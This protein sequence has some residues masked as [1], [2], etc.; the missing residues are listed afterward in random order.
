MALFRV[1]HP[2]YSINTLSPWFRSRPPS[3]SSLRFSPGWCLPRPP[4]SPAENFQHMQRRCVHTIRLVSRSKTK[5]PST[6]D[7]R[8][9]SQHHL[10]LGRPVCS[11]R[12]LE[13]STRAHQA[14]LAYR[15]YTGPSMSLTYEKVND[16]RAMPWDTIGS[17][18]MPSSKNLIFTRKDNSIQDLSLG[19]TFI[20]P[21]PSSAVTAGTRSETS[22][23]RPS[24]PLVWPI[25]GNGLIQGS[26]ISQGIGIIMP[27][28]FSVAV[29]TSRKSWFGRTYLI[30][31]GKGIIGL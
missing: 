21:S 11:L 26:W 13:V 6:S 14:D 1:V 18:W 12:A 8:A 10:D 29:R 24:S 9:C 23:P 2:I 7:S 22:G 20:A 5:P 31:S 28:R 25:F 4:Q 27:G 17:I 15:N 19:Q 16:C 3:S 30:T